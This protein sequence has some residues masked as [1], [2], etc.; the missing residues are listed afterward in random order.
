ML[1]WRLLKGTLFAVAEALVALASSWEILDFMGYQDQVRPY[2]IAGRPLIIIAVSLFGVIKAIFEDVE[3]AGS[4]Q[5]Y[6]TARK[7][8]RS[9]GRKKRT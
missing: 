1:G 7:K 4:Q 6:L 3:R 5:R 2:T 8:G 9:L